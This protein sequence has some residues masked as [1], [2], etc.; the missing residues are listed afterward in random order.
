MVGEPE[1]DEE[2]DVEVEES[3]ESLDSYASFA[4]ALFF[5]S[6]KAK[7]QIQRQTIN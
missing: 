2:E 3:S 7:Q 5:L 1:D 4:L 6:K